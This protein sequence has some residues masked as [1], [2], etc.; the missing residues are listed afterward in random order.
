MDRKKKKYIEMM[1]NKTDA[2][3]N[4]LKNICRSKKKSII[5]CPHRE[6]KEKKKVL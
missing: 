5:L 1:D 3:K 2:K 6:G 4:I